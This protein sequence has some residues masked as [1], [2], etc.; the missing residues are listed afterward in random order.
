MSLALS[1]APG[2][3]DGC[4]RAGKG[5]ARVRRK[6]MSFQCSSEPV[7]PELGFCLSGEAS[8]KGGDGENPRCLLEHLFSVR[9][10]VRERFRL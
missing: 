7:F 5:S 9:L 2:C 3:A 1:T 6:L 4:E 8:Q 10:L